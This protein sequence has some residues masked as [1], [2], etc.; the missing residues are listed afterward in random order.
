MKEALWNFALQAFPVGS[1]IEVESYKNE[2]FTVIHTGGPLGRM[3]KKVLE[4]H[5][6]WV[7]NDG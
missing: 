4:N 3:R 1:A 5:N 6:F 2:N 7:G